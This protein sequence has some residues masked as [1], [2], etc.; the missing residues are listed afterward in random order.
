M[1]TGIAR[2]LRTWETHRKAAYH[3]AGMPASLSDE[4]VESRVEHGRIRSP[5]ERLLPVVAKPDNRPRPCRRIIGIARQVAPQDGATF[6]RK[7]TGKGLLDPHEAVLDELLDL[8]IAQR[9]RCIV[10]IGRHDDP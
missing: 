6:L 10:F 3:F 7:R 4:L 1:P 8:R 9:A 2:I 5:P